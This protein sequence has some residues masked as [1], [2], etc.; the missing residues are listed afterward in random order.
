MKKLLSIT[1]ILCLIFN[2]VGC[3]GSSENIIETVKNMKLA[4]YSDKSIG[5]ALKNYFNDYD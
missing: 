2:F 3:S 5:N 4:D 1:L